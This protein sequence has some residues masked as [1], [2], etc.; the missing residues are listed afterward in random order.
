MELERLTQ[1]QV[2]E[3]LDKHEEV[4]KAHKDDSTFWCTLE[5][6]KFRNI[7]QC[8]DIRELNLS[9]HDLSRLNFANANAAYC[10]F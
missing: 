4:L 1:E 6:Q 8:K 5:S 9:N 10:L 2:D 3:L 7:F